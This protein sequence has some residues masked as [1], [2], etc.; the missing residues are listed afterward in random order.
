MK[1]NNFPENLIPMVNKWLPFWYSNETKNQVHDI[2]KNWITDQAPSRV[3]LEWITI[4]H[5][6]SMDLDDWI[7]AE[8]TKFWYSIFISIAD[9]TEFIPVLSPI[10]LD[11]MNKWTS[12]YLWEEK[13][14]FMLPRELAC[15]IVSLNDQTTRLSQ[16]AQIDYDNEMNVLNADF[17]ESKFKNIKRFDYEEFVNQYFYEDSPF[18]SQL[19]LQDEIA[20]KLRAKR[21]DKWIIDFDDAERWM[22]KIHKNWKNIAS[23]LIEEFMVATNVQTAVFEEKNYPGA[24]VFRNHMVWLK[25]KEIIPKQLERAFYSN[26]MMYHFW[27]KEENYTHFTSPMRRY[28][29]F[30]LHRQL[31]A[32]LR[33]EEIPYSWEDL[34]KIV[35]R[36]LNQQLNRVYFLEKSF[37]Y[38]EWLKKR[39]SRAKEK[40]EETEES[41][42]EIKLHI[43]NWVKK[44]LK[45]PEEIRNEIIET[46]ENSENKW[47][48]MW[49]IWAYLL[50]EE[51]EIINALKK[52][53]I[54]EWRYKNILN[55]IEQT[56]LIRW[57]QN[58]IFSIKYDEEWKVTIK[59]NWKLIVENS[60]N[61]RDAVIELFD[62]AL[63]K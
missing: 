21:L 59:I 58:K 18:H 8:K 52:R 7:W 35:N 63:K 26:K 51:K 40:C 17:Y 9:P 3:F 42:N 27:L 56:R 61:T 62:Y 24:W 6:E 36:Y 10:D 4:D 33:W 54:A 11:A 43:K 29:D 2:I 49:I 47:N 22:W 60:D 44:W 19:R 39:Y 48:W 38:E 37:H 53:V 28:L 15:D 20:Q 16:T 34:R 46:I 12:I 45:L 25:W 31:K 1:I 57:K 41:I 50:S 13:T 32:H 30:I 14:I 5:A 23:R 55:S